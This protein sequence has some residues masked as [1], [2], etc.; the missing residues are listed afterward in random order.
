MQSFIARFRTNAGPENGFSLIEVLIA[1]MVFMVLAVGVAFSLLSV[2]ALTNESRARQTATNLAAQE[3]DLGRSAKD[4]FTLGDVTRTVPTPVGNF[5]VTR[6]SQWVSGAGEDN[7]CG[8]GTGVLQYKRI[9]VTVTW[10]GMRAG[11]SPVQ[12]NTLLA[13]RDRINDPALG[14]IIVSA[15]TATGSGTAG[16]SVSAAPTAGVAGNTAV[17]LAG[18]PTDAQGCSYLLRVVPGT[19]DVT[20]SRAGYVNQQQVP[21]TARAAGISVAAG[22]SAAAGFVFDQ[23][24][25]FAVN[26]ASNASAGSVQ[27]PTNL[28]TSFISTAGIYVSAA[29]SA[30]SSRTL[31]LFPFP[32]GY[33]VMAGKYVAPNDTSSGCVSVDPEAW[34]KDAA[35]GLEGVRTQSTTT[36][37]AGLPMGLLTISGAAGKFVTAVSADGTGTPDPDCSVPMTYKFAALSS[38]GKIALPYGSWILYTG[39]TLGAKTTPVPAATVAVEAP[40][41]VAASTGIVTLDPRVVVAP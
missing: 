31:Q 24:A 28:D 35:T 5:Q 25:S 22:T 6:T 7:G 20:I 19:Y 10:D 27:F 3:I 1:M 23:A 16:V 41:L 33:A 17:A 9:D 2:L 8:T 37:A 36:A 26:Y 12:T 39:T 11:A 29:T 15:F 4:V 18:S 40:S 32:S 38:A 21:T 30:V 14:T 34:P 13:P